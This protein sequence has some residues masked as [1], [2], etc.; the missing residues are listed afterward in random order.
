MIGPVTASY[1]TNISY[2]YSASD[3]KM[4]I[5]WPVTHL[6]WFLQ[7][8]TNSLSKGISTNWV[9]IAGSDA[10]T[11]EVVTNNPAT[12]TEFFRLRHP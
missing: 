8:Q 9:D 11:S 10:L 3:H 12:P 4:T 2:S 5:S 7:T 1:S 6:G